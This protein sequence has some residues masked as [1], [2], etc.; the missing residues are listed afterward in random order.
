MKFFDPFW[1]VSFYKDSK[2]HSFWRGFGRLVFI[3]FLMSA[4]YASMFYVVFGKNIPT[5]INSFEAQ[6]INGYPSEL[7]LTIKDGMLSKN[8]KGEITLY[9]IAQFGKSMGVESKDGIQYFIVIDDTKEAT[10][11]S[12]N[13]AHAMAFFAKDGFIAK[14]NRGTQIYSYGDI[15]KMKIGN[16]FSKETISIIF[17]VCA[18][19]VDALPLIFTLL[20][21]ICYTLFAPLVN[22]TLLL[23]IAL[24]FKLVS[25][26][27][28]GFRA[29][30]KESYILTLYALP[31]VIIV[32]K[33]LMYLATIMGFAIKIP[34][35]TTILLFGFLWYMFKSK[36]RKR[37]HEVTEDIL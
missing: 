18:Q 14:S 20:I 9:P 2:S 4:V 10:L 17:A 23:F 5:Y 30:Y 16:T 28:I 24:V 1:K 35:F 36:D 32:E 7:I 21:V 31:V 27:I 29:G 13:D 3:C 15:E 37:K 25:K 22:L 12:F 11:T 19:F 33:V 26:Y 34:F 6:V 8:V